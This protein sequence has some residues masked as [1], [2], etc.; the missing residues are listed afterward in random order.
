MGKRATTKGRPRKKA[1][2]P[3]DRVSLGLRVTSETKAAL[4]DAAARSGRSQ[5]QE[6]ELRLERSFHDQRLMYDALELAYGATLAGLL[7]AVGDAM[8]NTARM[9]WFPMED[10]V[11]WHAHPLGFDEVIDSANT[12]LM[13]FRP[14]TDDAAPLTD[15]QVQFL[16][17]S[18][19]AYA[20]GLLDLLDRP[21]RSL[22]PTT[23]RKLAIQR[24]FL[25]ELM[26]RLGSTNARSK[27]D[28]NSTE[29][30]VWTDGA[31]KVI[32]E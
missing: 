19:S 16:K 5:S 14:D 6:A 24:E 11:P 22:L 2:K 21:S 4:D 23:E 26:V 9:A 31:G 12:V 29:K 7:L 17:G 20:N 18:G 13:A 15:D 8:K 10:L 28:E 32:K 1:P 30:E 27:R 3:G 25:G